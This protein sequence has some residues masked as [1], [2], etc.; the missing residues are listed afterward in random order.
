MPVLTVVVLSAYANPLQAYIHDLEE[1]VKSFNEDS[2]SSSGSISDLK[3]ELSKVKDAE[4]HS[5]Q[6]IAD[7]EARLAKSDE[8]VLSLQQSVERLEEECEARRADVRT[9]QTRLEQMQQDGEGWRSDLDEREKKI[10]RMEAELK[11]REEALKTTAETRDRLG[12][13]VNDVSAA[14]KNLEVAS[15]NSEVSSVHESDDSAESQLVALQQTHT[16]TLADLSSVSAKYRDALREIAD[17][18]AQLHEAKVNASIPPTPLSE[19]PERPT[20]VTSPRRRMTRGMSKDGHDGPLNGTG[21]RLLYR[22]AVSTESLHA[23]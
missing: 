1:K 4:T 23:R 8:S 5:S 22:H 15:I 7:L 9:L 3:R 17:L 16:A 18:A 2:L 21:R 6:Y 13:I 19:S 20:E 12:V 14:R 10:T 11:E